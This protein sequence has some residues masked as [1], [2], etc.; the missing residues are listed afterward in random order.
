MNMSEELSFFIYLL[1]QYAAYR[2][3][4]TGANARSPIAASENV[5]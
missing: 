2:N 1:E 3:A 5:K 4:K